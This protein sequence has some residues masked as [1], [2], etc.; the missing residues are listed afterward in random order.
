MSITVLSRSKT[1][2]ADRELPWLHAGDHLDQPTFH[3]RYEAM[4][5]KFRAELV[6]GVVIVPSPLGCPHGQSHVQILTWLGYYSMSTAGTK[7]YDNTT[8]IIDSQNEFQPDA[9]LVIPP[10]FG[11]RGVTLGQYVVG[12]PQLALEVAATSEAYDLF[13][14][15]R[16]YERAGV[17]E[18][19]VLIVREQEVRWFI[20]ND[21]RFERLS[22]DADGILRSIAFPGLWLNTAALFGDNPAEILTTL[23]AGLA[24]PAHAA[25]VEQLA[26]QRRLT[27]SKP[28]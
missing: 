16:V 2:P 13:E 7:A 9:Q 18:Y 15:F 14:K 27:E 8:T 28:S 23:Q 5:S 12:A 24:D 21:Q 1:P 10:E 11:G 22:A 17:Q 25:F 26:A 20:R 4:P 3:R 6:E 19:I